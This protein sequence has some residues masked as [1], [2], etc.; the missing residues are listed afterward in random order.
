[1]QHHHILLGVA[2]GLALPAAASL[3]PVSP[4]HRVVVVGG[5]HGNEYTGVWCIK[6]MEQQKSV[7][8]ESFPSLDVSTLL[9]NPKAHIENK[10][11]IHSDLNREFREESLIQQVNRESVE[12]MRARELD[13]SL[14]PKLKPDQHARRVDLIIDLHSTT[15]NMGL[16][17]IIPEGDVVMAQAAAY[18]LIKCEGA[19]C[20]M[21]SYP[22]AR[23]RPSLS[24]VGKHGLTI[25]VGPVPQGVVRHDAVETTQRAIQALMEFLEQR[26]TQGEDAVME[27]LRAGYPSGQV[28]IYRSAPAMVTGEMS[29]KI[30][31]PCDAENPNF[32]MWMVH[33]SLQDKDF[34]VVR[35]GDPMFV[36]LDGSIIPY[37]GSHGDEVILI[38]INEGGYYYKSSGTGITVAAKSHFDLFTGMMTDNGSFSAAAA[39]KE[40]KP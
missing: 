17:V 39:A 23:L 16:T 19:K 4:I 24:S 26:N 5:T 25:E 28:P 12:S 9:G 34:H 21:H 27:Q 18:V 7:I 6:A 30:P 8:A 22:D 29:G 32:P 40:L 10:R 20:L 37:N 2:G 36:A 11:F 38:F 15:T 14:G 35:T 3:P 13:A 31:W 33:K 1:M